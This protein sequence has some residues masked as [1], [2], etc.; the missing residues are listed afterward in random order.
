[1]YL[2][3][4]V[5]VQQERTPITSIL[6]NIELHNFDKFL[7]HEI[8]TYTTSVQISDVQHQLFIIGNSI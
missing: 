4:T 2:P 8:F 7:K 5:G 1:M 3:A 6:N